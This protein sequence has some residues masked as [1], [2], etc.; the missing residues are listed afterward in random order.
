MKYLPNLS[1]SGRR[2]MPWITKILAVGVC[3]STP[4]LA[5][6]SQPVYC[7]TLQGAWQG[8]Y[9]DYQRNQQVDEFIYFGPGDAYSSWVE[10]QDGGEPVFQSYYGQHDCVFD[11]LNIDRSEYDLAAGQT[12]EESASSMSFE[13]LELNTTYLKLQQDAECDGCPP[14]TLEYHKI[15]DEDLAH[16]CLH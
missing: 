15:P 11:Y 1:H 14:L 6:E 8:Q 16:G 2:C 10:R 9:F 13:V 7:Q 12:R 5:A 4:L 3:L